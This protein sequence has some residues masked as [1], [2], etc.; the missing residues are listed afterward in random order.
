MSEIDGLVGI[1]GAVDNAVQGDEAARAAVARLLPLYQDPSLS[2]Y[3]EFEEWLSLER[4]DSIDGPETVFP[5]LEASLDALGDISPRCRMRPRR[6]FAI[7]VGMRAFRDMADP[8]TEIGGLT[9]GALSVESLAGDESSA[10]A[11]QERLANDLFLPGAGP[12]GAANLAAWWSGLI[13]GAAKDGLIPS[14]TG[15]FPRPC[16]GRLVKVASATGPVA[17][18]E[19]DFETEEVTFEEAIKLIEPT[20]W[21]RCMPHF[22]CTMK[23]IGAGAVA[24]THRYREVVSSDCTSGKAAAFTAETELDFDFISVP[25]PANPEVAITNYQLSS[26]RPLTGDLI[27]V[28]EGSLVV[29]KTI[30]DPGPLRITTTKRIQFSY[31]FS[32]EA[33]AMIMCALGYTDVVADLLCC[34]ASI[35]K[36]AA[37][38]GDLGSEFPGSAPRRVRT[39]RRP[40]GAGGRFECSHIPAVQEM[41]G[42]WA[43]LL[44]DGAAAVELGAKGTRTMRRPPSDNRGEG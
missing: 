42:L 30:T 5:L 3:Q 18:L 38:G 16:T 19:T 27:R 31:P 12:E 44:R 21:K 1:Y 4:G 17:A 9:V 37:A 23:E 8:G 22:W 26:G 24:G 34:A 28:D 25:T 35:G 2:W 43:G 29:A 32:S 7:A 20:N 6:L 39:L 11:L 10:R 36:D 33:L 13:N 41:A 14:Q 40:A 15:M